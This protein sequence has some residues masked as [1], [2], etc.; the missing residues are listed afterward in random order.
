MIYASEALIYHAHAL[1]FRTFWRQHFNYGCGAF[2][3][4]LARAQHARGPISLEPRGFYLD[5]LRYPFSQA[6]GWR[7]LLL[8][9]LLVMSQVAN[10]VGFLWKGMSRK[11]MCEGADVQ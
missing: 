4:R 3:F 5:S 11:G 7:A 10:V 9:A 2:D 6:R 1:T 8:V